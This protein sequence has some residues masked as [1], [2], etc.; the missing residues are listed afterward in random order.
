MGADFLFGKM[1][2]LTMITIGI[3]TY[4]RTTYIKGA[5]ESCLRQNFSDFEILVKDT[6]SHRQI[7]EIVARFKDPRIRYTRNSSDMKIT[8]KLNELVR[9]GRGDWMLILCD[10]DELQ[11]GYLEAMAAKFQKWPDATLFR[12]RYRLIDQSGNLIRL[13]Q[14]SKE[15]MSAAEFLSRVFLPEKYFFKMNISG[16]LF[17]RERLLELGGFAELPIPWHTDRLA[18]SMLAAHG[19]CVFEEK[20][21]C[22]IRLH[23][24]SITSS[25]GKDLTSALESDMISKHL[26]ESFLQKV[27]K[28]II[29]EEDFRYLAEARRNLNTYMI[30]HFSRSLD[31]GF[32]TYLSNQSLWGASHLQALFDKMKEVNVTSFPSLR[33]YYFLGLLP[34]ALRNPLL[35]AFKNYKIKKWCA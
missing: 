5:L 24:G 16:I 35:K 14:N 3:P 27:A 19:Y 33:F 28:T 34:F 7:E 20:P 6:S 31:H 10:D 30:R 18:W 11:P 9:E 13:D 29:L 17:P 1:N 4:E 21:L 32:I 23:A 12:S 25:F 8:P 15:V 22:N 26:F 2:P